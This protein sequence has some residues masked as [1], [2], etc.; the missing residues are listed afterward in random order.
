MYVIPTRERNKYTQV[1]HDNGFKNSY[2]VCCLEHCII[3]VRVSIAELISVIN[4]ILLDIH[5]INNQSIF[6]DKHNNC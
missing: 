1:R 3:K 2:T 5:F 4:F 6:I